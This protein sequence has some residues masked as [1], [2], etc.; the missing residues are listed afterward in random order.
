MR[1]TV[2][3]QCVSRDGTKEH[4]MTISCQLQRILGSKVHFYSDLA[5]NVFLLRRLVFFYTDNHIDAFY[6]AS[7]DVHVYGDRCGV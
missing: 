3:L 7:H 4:Y 6:N 2:P 1:L 5:E